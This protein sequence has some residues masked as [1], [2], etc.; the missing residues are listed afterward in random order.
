MQKKP[1]L[2]LCGLLVLFLLA[3]SW[4]VTAQD[5]PAPVLATEYV[6]TIE[7][8]ISPALVMGA[9]VDGQRQSIPITGGSISGPSIKGEV[10]PGGADYQVQQADG[11]W[12]IRAI[13]MLRTNDGALINVVNEGIIVPPK[14]GKNAGLYFRCQP[15]FTA[16]NGNYGWLNDKENLETAKKELEALLEPRQKAKYNIIKN[17]WWNS[18][19]EE[20]DKSRQMKKR[21]SE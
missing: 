4:Q 20:I 10:V 5:Q 2:L 14:P 3:A 19:S 13:Y 7:A 8:T 12:R 11:S 6:F 21:E 18:V 9:S 15:H 17:V 1:D 16:P